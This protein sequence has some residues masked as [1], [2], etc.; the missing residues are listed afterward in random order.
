MLCHTVPV[1]KNGALVLQRLLPTVIDLSAE[2]PLP[3]A[4]SASSMQPPAAAFQSQTGGAAACVSHTAGSVASR[5]EQIA[6]VPAALPACQ[7]GTEPHAMAANGSPRDRLTCQRSTPAHVNNQPSC[8][9]SHSSGNGLSMALDDIAGNQPVVAHSGVQPG[10]TQHCTDDVSALNPAS[11]RAILGT[12]HGEE[13]QQDRQPENGSKSSAVSS[14]A[15]MKQRCAM[16]GWPSA[17]IT[18]VLHLEPRCVGMTETCPSVQLL[19]PTVS[20]A[21]FPVQAA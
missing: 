19:L 13:Q 10:C 3:D 14:I 11:S 9:P 2:S 7:S 20:L 12:L 21:Q 15:V 5:L 17:F 1:S 4:A 18:L 6:E 8:N 16:Y